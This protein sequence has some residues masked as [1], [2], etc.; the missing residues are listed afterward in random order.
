MFQLKGS[1][2]KKIIDKWEWHIENM[3]LL[4][5]WFAKFHDHV[6]SASVKSN[7]QRDVFIVESKGAKYYVKYS[8]P[9]SMFQKSRSIIT[10]KSAAEFNSSKLLKKYG[11]P[12]PDALGWGRKGSESMLITK[13]VTDAVNARK[14]WFSTAL[15]NHKKQ[16][17]FLANLAAFLEKFLTS[18]LFHPDFHPGNLLVSDK[19]GKISFILIDPYGIV[20]MKT[21]N[22]SKIFEM[23]CIIGAFR[24][25]LNDSQGAALIGKIFPDYTAETCMTRWQQIVVAESKKTVKLW[26]KR[27]DRI[28]SDSR[29]SQVFERDGKNIRIRKSLAGELV[30]NLNDALKINNQQFDIQELES[31]Q[32]ER[33]WLKSFQKEFH[34]LPQALPLA[35]IQAPESQ[36]III[37]EKK[38]TTGLS[39]NE[40][41]NREALADCRA[42]GI[43]TKN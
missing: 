26:D 18:G 35:W 16:E 2:M 39:E 36:D 5:S 4:D 7:A 33:Q 17:Q 41:R 28:I 21:L 6:K 15:N 20:K 22:F 8:H 23:L 40:I 34:R 25:E 12:T 9:N 14:F 24:G 38:Y 31:H 32:A 42:L 29:Y 30:I 19:D 37:F 11:I 3:D 13:A 43:A 10:S 1:D 27:K